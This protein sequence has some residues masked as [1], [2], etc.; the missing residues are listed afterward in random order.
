MNLGKLKSIDA[1]G[2]LPIHF[3]IKFYRECRFLMETKKDADERPS[4]GFPLRVD[5]LTLRQDQEYV[6][7]L[8]A[9]VPEFCL[10]V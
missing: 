10:C 5:S 3:S 9:D 1:L 4:F 6:L 8:D 2:M 7:S